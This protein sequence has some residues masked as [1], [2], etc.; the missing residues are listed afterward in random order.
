M[1]QRIAVRLALALAIAGLSLAPR[2]ASAHNTTSVCWETF[3]KN[4][5]AIEW[6]AYT[7]SGGFSFF[8]WSKIINGA[9]A[10]CPA[11][12][13]YDASEAQGCWMW[14]HLCGNSYIRV[15]ADAHIHVP[16]YLGRGGPAVTRGPVQ[17]HTAGFK[18]HMYMEKQGVKV[19]SD[20][21]YIQIK[22]STNAILSV[23][24]AQ[25]VWWDSGAYAPNSGDFYYDV[26][27]FGWEITEAALT[28]VAGAGAAP[29]LGG[30]YFTMP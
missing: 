13:A 28:N 23:K 4:D 18:L 2:S 16:D 27:D 20:L 3:T 12:G 17:A 11:G 5:F 26:S 1:K 29:Q 15:G 8:G 9:L 14:R 21:D 25:G 10:T 6:D 19:L 24:D 22:G 30:I 7:Q